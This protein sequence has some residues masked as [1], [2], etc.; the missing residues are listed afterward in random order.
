M[1]LRL[2][3]YCSE[4][5]R[6]STSSRTRIWRD[7][8]ILSLLGFVV[9]FIRPTSH[10]L[11][12]WQ[13]A[14]RVLVAREMLDANQWLVPTSAGQAYLSKPPAFYWAQMAMA[15]VMGHRVGEL[16]LRLV[17]ALC[18]M[19]GVLLTWL[20]AKDIFQDDADDQLVSDQRWRADVGLW[21]A[22]S[23]MTG[24]LFVRSGRIGE[25]DIMLVPVVVGGIWASVH[26][27]RYARKNH[28]TAF[29]MVIVST[30][31]A[32]AA[33]MTK[34]PPALLAPLLAPFG[35]MALWIALK[36]P[37]PSRTR[38]IAGAL[39]GTLVSL[40]AIIIV[41]RSSLP[42]DPMSLA[43]AAVLIAISA[44]LG[45]LAAGL[46]T[47][48]RA[49]ELFRVYSRTHPVAVA[50]VPMAVLLG[51]FKLVAAQIGADAVAQGTAYETADNLR[52]LVLLAPIRNL[53][54]MSYGA[55][56]SSIGTIIAII[57]L[58]KDRPR[59]TPGLCVVLSW[60]VLSFFALSIL[61]KGVPRYLTPVW[62]AM[63]MLAGV[64]MASALRDL[65]AAKH[66]P[67]TGWIAV[68]VLALSQ[69]WWYSMG[70]EQSYA[71]RSPRSLFKE[72]EPVLMD[73]KLH[74]IATAAFHAPAIEFYVDRPV[75]IL[76]DPNMPGSS[77]IRPSLSVAD[78]ARDLETSQGF[79]L[80]FARADQAG[81]PAAGLGDE[82]HDA[83]LDW[84]IVPTKA[85]FAIDANRSNAIVLRVQ[86][87]R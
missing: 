23:L 29:G 4:T 33:V 51:W 18:A 57:W 19:A 84:S 82:L 35:A 44:T 9:F 80:V 11:T 55:G 53:E 27:W 75:Q 60:I 87:Q 43:G 63:A 24:V 36:P 41:H 74:T 52:L 15:R 8:S 56:L 62:P 46:T 32:V 25:L 77:A 59:F 34:G 10:G 39:A 30:I 40:T 64:W 14:Q 54:A 22:L 6:P 58:I 2:G 20:A 83:N 78:I 47:T 61:G 37:E 13:E 38:K 86:H 49:F 21:S 42:A 3:G 67:R 16:E 68:I 5:L 1:P 65:K 31:A 79:W 28:R 85:S 17:V 7:L 66:L 48:T 12:N 71:F 50:I 76:G 70:R 26:A 81:Q 69:S 73:P 72:L 45:W